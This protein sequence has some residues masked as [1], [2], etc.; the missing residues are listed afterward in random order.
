MIYNLGPKARPIF[1]SILQNIQSGQLETGAR[2]PSH[3]ELAE[4]YGVATL[5]IHQVLSKME[6]DGWIIRQQGRGTFVRKHTA[7]AVLIVDDEPQMIAF[8]TIHVRQ[9]GYLPLAATNPAEGL[10]LLEANP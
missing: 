10:A 6:E 9:A 7:P 2:L 3:H 8:L 1:E 4:E 5:T